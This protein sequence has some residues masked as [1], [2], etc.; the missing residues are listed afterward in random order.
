MNEGHRW[1]GSYGIVLIMLVATMLVIA[2]LGDRQYG[3]PIAVLIQAAA[4]LLIYRASGVTKNWMRAAGGVAIVAVLTTAAAQAY[5]GEFARVLAGV[6]LM[7]L[8]VLGP[9]VI[10]RRLQDDTHVSLETVYAALCIYLIIGLFFSVLFALV[11][12]LSDSS[13]Y[14]EIATSTSMD[15][16]YFSFTTLTTLGYGDL[17]PVTD[18]GRML[19]ITEALIG[20]VYLV[21]IVAL[22]VTNLGRE[23]HH[24]QNRPDS[25]EG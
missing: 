22:I 10:A 12:T 16:I 14:A 11:G 9:Y 1:K 24:R 17:T 7:V 5:G 20:Q 6:F 21:T 3:G 18:V 23:R 25:D 13:F 19:A 15:S 2:V 4:V 8:L